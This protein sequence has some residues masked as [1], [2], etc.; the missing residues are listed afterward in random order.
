MFNST[1][2]YWSHPSEEAPRTERVF[3]GIKTYVK[4]LSKLLFV[5]IK[6]WNDNVVLYE[7]ND[8]LEQIVSTSWLSLEPSD[9]KKHRNDGNSSL[10][11]ELNAGEEMLFG[12][13]IKV[14]EGNRFLLTINQEQ[15][16]SRV[17]ELVMDSNGNP[18]V[19][20][21][22]N[23]IT[24]RIEYAYVHMKKGIIPEA[25]F[26]NFYGKSLKDGTDV[27]ELIRSN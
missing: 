8:S 11:S 3:N 26:M 12:C 7:Y 23:G 16:S 13:T 17:F 5:V 10:R 1:D 4:D 18:A 19:I 9:A 20:G 6:S 24:C 27:V 25:D 21:T 15:L 2:A 14:V 22:I